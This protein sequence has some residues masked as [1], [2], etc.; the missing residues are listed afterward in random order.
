MADAVRG[1]LASENECGDEDD[2]D[3]VIGFESEPVGGEGVRIGCEADEENRARGISGCGA[4]V[5]E[6]GSGWDKGVQGVQSG[7]LD[8]GAEFFPCVSGL[9]GKKVSNEGR[10]RDA[11]F[12]CGDFG[13]FGEPW[14]EIEN[15]RFEAFLGGAFDDSLGDY[16]ESE[17]DGRCCRKDR[18]W[19]GGFDFGGHEQSDGPAEEV[20]TEGDV[21]KFGESA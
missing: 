3:E 15:P 4:E 19:V 20:D 10:P 17:D 5:R 16:G 14:E 11:M 9:V 1:G 8:R 12:L 18:E 13:S 21:A 2:G 6:G 7:R